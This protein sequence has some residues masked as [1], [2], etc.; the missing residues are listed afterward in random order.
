L[1]QLIH[2]RMTIEHIDATTAAKNADGDARVARGANSGRSAAPFPDCSGDC[3][4][5]CG[6]IVDWL[7]GLDLASR[8]QRPGWAYYPT[9][10]AAVQQLTL[11]QRRQAFVQE[12]QRI[13]VA[14]PL[15]RCQ[16]MT[17]PRKA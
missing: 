15:S 7:P 3:G 8:A 4:A 12:S 1:S 2:I 13:R 16:V 10:H 11:V 5:G 14:T 6:R 9:Q 17:E